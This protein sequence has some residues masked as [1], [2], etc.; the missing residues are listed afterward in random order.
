MVHLYIYI[1]IY[2]FPEI[3]IMWY[4][5]NSNVSYLNCTFPSQQRCILKIQIQ[6]PRL[7]K[8]LNSWCDWKK[9]ISPW[10]EPLLFCDCVNYLP[11][12]RKSAR[13]TWGC[14]FNTGRF[15]RM[16]QGLQTVTA[17]WEHWHQAVTWDNATNS[18]SD[19]WWRNSRRLRHSR[20]ALSQLLLFFSFSPWW[21]FVIPRWRQTSLPSDLSEPCCLWTSRRS[22]KKLFAPQ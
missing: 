19:I 7:C 4:V 10:Q 9:K 1:Y 22:P 3:R 17:K 12:R 8:P 5:P 16:G 11:L 15:H 13:G 18:M 6:N 14:Y 2:I 20:P 21:L